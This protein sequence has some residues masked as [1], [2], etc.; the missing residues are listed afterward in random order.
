[1]EEIVTI[2]D[3]RVRLA[4]VRSARHRVALVPT[5]GFL[6]EGHLALAD[7]ARVRADVVVMSLFV[8][9]LQF[10]PTEDFA[11]YPR[12]FERDRAL[13]ASRGV[14]ILFAPSVEEMYGAGSQLRITGAEAASRWEGAVRPGHFDGVLTVVAK[15]L[16]AT[17]PDVACFGQKDI[18]QVTLIRQLIREFNFDVELVVVPIV[19]EPDG[20]ALSSR[21]VY[22]NAAERLAALSL[23]RALRAA[24]EGWHAGVRD[25]ERLR[26][27]IVEILATAVPPLR[28]DYIAIVDP[29]RLAPIATAT[30]GSVIALAVPVGTTRLIDNVILG[31][32]DFPRH[33]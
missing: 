22:L 10:G 18:Q 15:L 20:L 13:A 32:D 8:N 27:V 25:A 24:V 28:A 23:S 30:R 9:P 6:H 11:R 5:M 31:D 21:N 17:A 19:R 12:D 14:D 3:L 26:E 16:I 2:S 33:G 29:E 1:M 4:S 7:A